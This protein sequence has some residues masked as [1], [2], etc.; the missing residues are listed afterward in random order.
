MASQDRHLHPCDR[1]SEHTSLLVN[2]S[3]ISLLFAPDTFMVITF[4]A[5]FSLLHAFDFEPSGNLSFS[6]SETNTEV[7]ETAIR[8]LAARGWL[9]IVP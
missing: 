4:A 2:N 6:L 8:R 9:Q 3:N 7:T 5:S 1:D